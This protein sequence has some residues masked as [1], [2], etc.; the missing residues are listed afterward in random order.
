[1]YLV[2]EMDK[3]LIVDM[4]E[5]TCSC[6]L[7]Q[8]TG[9]PCKHAVA[10]IAKMHESV[11]DYT[12]TYYTVEMYR[13][14][15]EGVINPVP[16]VGDHAWEDDGTEVV[17]NPDVHAPPER[18]R[19]KRIPSQVVPNGAKCGLCGRSGHNRRTCKTSRVAA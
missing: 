12:D 1:M 17:R 19:K 16:N 3:E 13:R 11:Y 14:A 10:C 9:I 15:Y 6:R 2:E 8:I 4:M 18:R 7:W 5:M